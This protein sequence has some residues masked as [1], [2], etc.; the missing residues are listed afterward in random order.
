MFY[1]KQH[2]YVNNIEI[3]AEN[4]NN[5]EKILITFKEGFEN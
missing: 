5:K 3:N 2:F 1:Q 4:S